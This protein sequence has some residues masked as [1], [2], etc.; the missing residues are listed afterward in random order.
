MISVASKMLSINCC[1]GLLVKDR[2]FGVLLA[3]HCVMASDHFVNFI[4]ID[5]FVKVM[6]TDHCVS[7]MAFGHFVEVMAIDD[8][9]NF[10]AIEISERSSSTKLKLNESTKRNVWLGLRDTSPWRASNSEECDVVWRNR[11]VCFLVR[12]AS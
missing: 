4:A 9:V 8:C 3:Y 7:F 12:L 11:Y 6:A 10:M 5:H 2:C 1:L